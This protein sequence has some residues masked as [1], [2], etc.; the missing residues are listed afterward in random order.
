MILAAT[1]TVAGLAAAA[2]PLAEARRAPVNAALRAKAAGDQVD[3]PRGVTYVRRFGG[4]RGPVALCIH[5]LTTPGYV[6]IPIAESLARQGYRVIVPDLYGRGLSDRPAGVQNSAFFVG[7]LTDLCDR[8]DLP[9]DMLVLGYSMGGAIASAFAHARPASVGRLVLLA[10]CGLGHDLGRFNRFCAATPVLG[11]WAMLALG[12]IVL[13]RGVDRSQPPHPAV[14]DLASRQAAETR[15][16]GSLPAI[17]SAQRHILTED[18]ATLH[19]K[20][21]LTGLPVLAI[22]GEV[23]AII[24]LS[25]LGRLTQANRNARQMVMTGAGH[26]LPFSHARD[27]TDAILAFLEDPF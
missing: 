12:G 9:D 15:L 4:V 13:R 14:P 19:R 6:W 17:L 23:D 2:A 1:L 16:R 26:A 3:L 10:P 7:Q 20:I 25:S 18:Q 8:L 27:V 11:D 22:W 24:P 21:A 5:G